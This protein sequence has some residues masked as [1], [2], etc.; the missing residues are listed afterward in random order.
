MRVGC[1][2]EIKVHE[3]RVGLIPASAKTLV[4]S[5]HQ[6]LIEKGAG[7]GAGIADEEY[8][9]AGAQI[10]S[11]SDELWQRADMIVKVKEPLE[12]E[13]VSMRPGQIL[14]TFLH[15]AAEPRL[16][17]VLL[18][19]E[20]TGIAYETIQVGR[21]L[22][23]LKPM[24][25]VAGR[26]SIQVGAWCL[27]KHQGGK[28]L[29]LCGV[30]GVKKGCVTILGG[31]TVGVSAA[32]VAL[33]MGAQVTLLD[34]NLERLEYLDHISHGRLQTLF[35]SEHNIEQSVLE[36]D[37]VI[38]GVL[39]AGAKAPKLVT[40]H[41]VSRMSKGSVIVDVAIDQGGC[42]ETMKPTNHDNPTFLVDGVVHYGVTN[43]PGAVARTSTFALAHATMPYMKKIADLGVRAALKNDAALM[44]G[45][46]TYQGKVTYK[47]VA[48]AHGMEFTAPD[49]L[50]G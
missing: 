7:L 28:G 13:Y 20:V 39:I 18:E 19:R 30:T 4:T 1:P 45:L 24:S 6:V 48:E 36:A 25:E 42:I 50:L 5:G 16:T 3:Y 14:Y 47:A 10:I 21:T 49:A 33:G 2:K 38:G 37:L 41:L 11:T 31:G 9:Q 40:K 8:S 26:M 43:M 29:L 15:L 27:E 17:H 34:T 35:S 12:A 44:A 46:N 32:S 23:L 22:P